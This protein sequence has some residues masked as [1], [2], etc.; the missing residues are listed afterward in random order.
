MNTLDFDSSSVWHAVQQEWPE[1]PWAT[2]EFK[3]G[4]FH[5]VA[6]L[7][8]QAVVR[9][10]F[11]EDHEVRTKN[12]FFNLAAIS[13]MDLPFQTPSNLSEVYTTRSW[14]AVVS[15]FVDGEHRDIVDWTDVRGVLSDVL[16]AFQTAARPIAESFLP[17]RQ[18]CGGANWPARVDRIIQ[19]FNERERAA[20]MHVVRDVLECEAEVQPTLVHG[21]FGLHNVLWAEGRVTGVIDFD[22]ATIGDPAIDVAPLIGLFGASKLAQI[23]DSEMISRAKLHRASLTLQVAAAADLIND[24]KLR[25]HALRNFQKRFR[26]GSLYDPDAG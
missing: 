18:W 19:P 3:H 9:I 25:N 5:H 20:A 22:H 14:S 21:D 12:E 23:Y 1:L 15:S 11:G 6:V 26:D 16:N 8:T 24:V 7:G 17:V 2:A 4:A 13:K 10:G